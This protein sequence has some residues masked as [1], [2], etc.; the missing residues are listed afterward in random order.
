[1]HI[2]NFFDIIRY[3]SVDK[4]S[5]IPKDDFL[6]LIKKENDNGNTALILACIYGKTETAKFILSNLSPDE[7]LSQINNKNID[8][9]TAFTKAIQYINLD[10]AT[11]ILSRLNIDQ[12]IS[13]LTDSNLFGNTPLIWSSYNNDFESSKFIL[14]NLH[15]YEIIR[16]QLIHED[17]EGCNPLDYA[18]GMFKLFKFYHETI[19]VRKYANDRIS[20]NKFI[21]VII[22]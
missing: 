4:L 13:Q 10:V 3:E 17:N 12:R 18:Y 8:D 2:E 16:K 20:L 1:M 11:F 5:S 15:D 21:E 6:S 14:L 9:T 22:L 19:N 7:Q